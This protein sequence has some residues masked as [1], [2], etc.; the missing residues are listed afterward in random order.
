MLRIKIILCLC[1]SLS[2]LPQAFAEQKSI[3]LKDGSVIRGE[4]VNFSNGLYTVK[5]ANLGE[6]KLS[7]SNVVGMVNASAAAA[8]PQQAAQAPAMGQ[9]AMGA[10][11][12]SGAMANVQNQIMG[13]PQTMVAIQALA[14]DPE[15][16][17]MM[18][19]PAFVQQLMG[20][21]SGNNIEGLSHDPRIQ[22]LMSNPKV[23]AIVQQVQPPS[24]Q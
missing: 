20:A 23:Q 19:D 9:G 17:A 2:V 18:S 3:T 15:I 13:N 21:L 24:G 6:L 22:K 10:G 5:T 8:M 14:E 12:F 4:L 16:M 11:N 1:L 7:E